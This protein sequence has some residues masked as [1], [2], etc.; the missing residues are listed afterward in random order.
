VVQWIERVL[1]HFRESLKQAS[2]CR[3]YILITVPF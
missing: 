3:W 1:V 2:I